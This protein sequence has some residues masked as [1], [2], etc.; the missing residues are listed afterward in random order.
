M[1]AAK[2]STRTPLGPLRYTGNTWCSDWPWYLSKI[3]MVTTRLRCNVA[4]NLL[5][6]PSF[7]FCLFCVGMM[8][9][10]VCM[11]FIDCILMQHYPYM[12]R[13]IIWHSQQLSHCFVKQFSWW[14]LDDLVTSGLGDLVTSWLSAPSDENIYMTMA[15]FLDFLQMTISK[16]ILF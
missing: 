3:Q 2:G 11:A 8:C 16:H 7:F 13:I 4:S 15:H 10:T 6:V 14:L 9:L 12:K 5:A 1:P